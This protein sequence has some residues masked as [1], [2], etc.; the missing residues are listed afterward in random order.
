MSTEGQKL[1]RNQAQNWGLCKDPGNCYKSRYHLLDAKL[2][3]KIT[4]GVYNIPNAMLSP[5]SILT[6]VS[7]Q[8][9]LLCPFYRSRN[10][11]QTRCR[12]VRGVKQSGSKGY[13]LNYHEILC[14][15]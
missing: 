12:V 8:Q 3:I 1:L 14:L 9:L 6:H 10:H 13:P 7:S 4:H 15:L 11:Q 5:L 2:A